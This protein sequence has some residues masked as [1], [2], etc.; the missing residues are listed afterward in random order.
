MH[1]QKKRRKR[2]ISGAADIEGHR[3]EWALISEPQW[4]THGR[5]GL[6]VLVRQAKGAYREMVIEYPFD[7]STFVP[8]RPRLTAAIVEADIREAMNHGWDPLSRGRTFTFMARTKLQLGQQ[9][10]GASKWWVA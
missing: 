8:Q 10:A 5:K 1:G 2:S 3:L 4:T 7:R 9:P 6:C